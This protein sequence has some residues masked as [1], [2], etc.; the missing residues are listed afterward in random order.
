MNK[1]IMKDVGDAL[2]MYLQESDGSM[3]MVD[4]GI[5]RGKNFSEIFNCGCCS[6][7]L[8]FCIEHKIDAF[9]LSHFH[10]D[11]YNGFKEICPLYIFP[12]K[13]VFFPRIPENMPYYTEFKIMLLTDWIIR[14][15]NLF[16]EILHQI[17][18][19]SNKNVNIHLVSQGDVFLHNG[20]AYE[21]LW[22][23]KQFD[24]TQKELT[25]SVKE[26]ISKFDKV[27]MGNPQ[28]KELY[29]KLC[30]LNLDVNEDNGKLYY[31]KES[32][33]ELE[34]LVNEYREEQSKSITDTDN[35]KEFNKS[36]R[37]AAN[38]LSIAFRQEDNVLFLGDLESHELKIVAGNL[39][40]KNQ[41]F[42]DFLVAAHHGTHWNRAL[43]KIEC[44]NC[45]VS[46]GETLISDVSIEYKTIATKF[47]MTSLMGDIIL[48]KKGPCICSN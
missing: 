10:L 48:C 28:F 1:I 3:L 14:G 36:L 42:Y 16:V 29:D 47:Y 18:K 2:N 22:P 45:L 31:D 23:P 11:H 30:V 41:L 27:K 12:L 5:G 44:E 25:N 43:S 15:N 17:L 6:Y 9:L 21:V 46:V 19:H 7:P 35:Y 37:E 24:A 40:N 4:F 32:F 8:N 33:S 13:D 38:R 39:E 26:A 20:H 34:K